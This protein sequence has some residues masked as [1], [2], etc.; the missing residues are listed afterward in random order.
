MRGN[1]ILVFAPE[2]SQRSISRICWIALLGMTRNDDLVVKA[3]DI[4]QSLATRGDKLVR[5]FG[6]GFTL[7]MANALY[8]CGKSEQSNPKELSASCR[9]LLER[10]QQSGGFSAL[11][12]LPDIESEELAERAAYWQNI[13]RKESWPTL[14]PT[15]APF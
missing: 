5:W 10:V 1:G 12:F 2:F 15:K 6:E 3:K 4:Y 13:Y 14:S 9:K 11:R 8:G 7:D